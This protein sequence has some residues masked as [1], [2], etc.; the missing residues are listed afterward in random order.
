MDNSIEECR[1]IKSIVLV[2]PYNKILEDK[3]NR[4]LESLQIIEDKF[5]KV[6]KK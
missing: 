4:L 2:L 1:T 3:G 6:F 5:P